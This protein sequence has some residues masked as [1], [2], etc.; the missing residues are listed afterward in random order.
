M[1]LLS[2]FRL[3]LD[4]QKKVKNSIIPQQHNTGTTL[5]TNPLTSMAIKTIKIGILNILNHIM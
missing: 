2:I 5:K 3:N 1:D 4:I